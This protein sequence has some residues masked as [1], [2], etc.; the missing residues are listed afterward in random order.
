LMQ[1][2]LSK[3]ALMGSSSIILILRHGEL[4][5]HSLNLRPMQIWVL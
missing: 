3:S 4:G 1:D 5:E 2:M